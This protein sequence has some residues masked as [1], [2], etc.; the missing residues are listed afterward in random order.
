[1]EE[2][3]GERSMNDDDDEHVAASDSNVEDDNTRKSRRI[4]NDIGDRLK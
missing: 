2:A 3:F 1:M 4:S